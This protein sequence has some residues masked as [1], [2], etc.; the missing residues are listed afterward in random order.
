MPSEVETIA[1]TVSRA[2]V[3][4]AAVVSN[5]VLRRQNAK[6]GDI[7]F[8]QG[9]VHFDDVMEARE[10][11]RELHERGAKDTTRAA[12]DRLSTWQRE[13]RERFLL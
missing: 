7:G 10:R 8:T 6:Y 4:T 13:G 1:E 3:E 11:N 2:G 9:F 12:I 5:W